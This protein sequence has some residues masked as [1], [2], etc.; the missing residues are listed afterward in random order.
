MRCFHYFNLGED[1]ALS[2]M[3]LLFFLC[4]PKALSG[5]NKK[6]LVQIK[7][8]NVDCQGQCKITRNHSICLDDAQDGKITEKGYFYLIIKL[9]IPLV[10]INYKI[11]HFL[12]VLVTD[13]YSI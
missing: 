9:L 3:F 13:I 5:S 7:N 11:M 10:Y 4:S 2:R 6:W 1:K 8:N 12:F